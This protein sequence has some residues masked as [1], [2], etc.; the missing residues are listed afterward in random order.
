MQAVC[1]EV[2]LRHPGKEVHLGDIIDK[3][4]DRIGG[5]QGWL[6]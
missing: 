2:L 6:A 3:A 5:E 1:R 4:W